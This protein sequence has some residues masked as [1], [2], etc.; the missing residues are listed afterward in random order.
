MRTIQSDFSYKG[1]RH[2]VH[3]TDVVNFLLTSCGDQV[4]SLHIKFLKPLTCQAYFLIDTKQIQNNID[5]SNACVSGYF[6]DKTGVTFHYALIPNTTKAIKHSYQYDESCL[7]I[8]HTIPEG[9]TSLTF[10]YIN[11][12]TFIEELVAA[13]KHLCEHDSQADGWRLAALKLNYEHTFVPNVSYSLSISRSISSRYRS[14]TLTCHLSSKSCK[15]LG[16][17]EFIRLKS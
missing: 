10:Q 17:V 3:G 7:T 14:A 4:H 5:I 2:Y 9:Q 16:E 11:R 15:N 8:F 13:M 6:I 12:F 1:D